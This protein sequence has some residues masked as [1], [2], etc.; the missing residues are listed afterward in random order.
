MSYSFSQLKRLW[1]NA[2]GQG[3]LVANI[4]AA[5]ALAESGGNPSAYHVDANGSV[6][7]GLWQINS[8]HGYSPSSSFNPQDNAK[9]AVAVW[10]SSGYGAWST[11]NSGAYK[12]Y[13]PGASGPAPG[14]QSMTDPV[15]GSFAR[16]DQGVDYVADKPVR[17]LV[18]GT[19]IDVR[20]DMAAPN[21]TRIIEKFD[22]PIKIGSHTYYG[23]YYSEEQAMVNP[24]QHVS[25]GQDIMESGSNELGFL[26]GGNLQMPPLVGGVGA[27][28][29][30]TLEGQQ[31]AQL[32]AALGGPAQPGG[33]GI[34]SD[35]TNALKGVFVTPWENVASNVSGDAGS[36]NPFNWAKG[37]E[38]LILQGFFILIGVGLCLVGLGLIAWTVMGKVGAPGIVGMAQ[39]QMRIRQSGARIEES[40]RASTVREAQASER[41]GLNRESGARAERRL[42]VSEGN[43]GRRSERY[44]VKDKPNQVVRK[45]QG[46]PAAGAPRRD[47]G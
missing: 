35:I 26:V 5:I 16:I 30:P 3:G 10:K 7:R 12:Q 22:Q 23:G 36:L 34:G 31:Y 38:S 40:H 18:P 44:V 37:I 39:T 2:G 47:R 19:I 21:P 11:Y 17:A 14:Q 24:G 13:L 43:L 45:K 20:S 33:G 46:N 9:Q 42:R 41:I 32:V 29:Q 6:D 15:H 25:A 27:G 1:T 4:M 8:V 28:T